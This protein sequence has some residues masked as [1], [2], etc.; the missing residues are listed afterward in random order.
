MK[1][2]HCGAHRPL[3]FAL[4]LKN[5]GNDITI[6]THNEKII[7]FCIKENINYLN[8]EFI[9]PTATSIINIFALKKILDD[10]LKKIEFDDEDCF[11][12]TS[13]IKCYDAFYL[14]KELSKKG[15]KVYYLNSNGMEFE[16]YKPPISKPI[17]L[18][19]G[20]IR[21]ALKLILNLDLMYYTGRDIPIIGVD[22]SF[23]KKHNIQDCKSDI[24]S[25][26]LVLKS[27]GKS[28]NYEYDNLIVS[29]GPLIEAHIKTD[30]V[31]KL[32]EN[33]FQL[34]IEFAFK[35]HPDAAVSSFYDFFKDC[36]EVPTNIPAEML[37]KN[38]RKN[39]ISIFSASLILASQLK[40]IKAISLLELVE[41]KDQSWKNE[42]KEELKKSSNNNILFPNNFEELKNYL[43]KL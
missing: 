17:F 31:K 22:D 37:Y 24:L 13:K 8:Y 16:K 6:I 12:L 38:V 34:P 10:I 23:L 33:L 35:K 30:S 32:Y 26:E 18:K 9:R 20:I 42:V 4:A 36:R 2:I 15:C 25:E 14:S 40:N 7:K 11:F 41:W 27:I 1:Y 3:L 29:Q 39:V 28:K 43:I 19:G 5:L 21:L